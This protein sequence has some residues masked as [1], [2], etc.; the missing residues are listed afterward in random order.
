M[1]VAA[2][3]FLSTCALA[4]AAI[5]ALSGCGGDPEPAAIAYTNADGV[6]T[7]V[8]GTFTRTCKDATA[9]LMQC[10]R[11]ELA[12]HVNPAAQS[13]GAKPIDSA[14]TWA[15]NLVSDGA[16]DGTECTI[17]GGTYEQGSIE[18][19]EVADDSVQFTIT[20]TSNGKFDADGTY[21]ALRCK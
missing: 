18:I 17:R 20:G 10:G 19:V 1:R 12:V 6:L 14:D 8:A 2:G 7:V 3:P 15:E 16:P 9:I 11:W 5:G 21:D 4:F 13:G